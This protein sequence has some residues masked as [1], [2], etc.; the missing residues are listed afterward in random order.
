[1]MADRIDDG[2]PAYPTLWNSAHASDWLTENGMTLRDRFAI[3][4][5]CGMAASVGFQGGPWNKL[6]T[7]AYE[8]ADAMLVARSTKSSVEHA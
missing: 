8:A 3:A 6:S 1:M 4:A 5:L 7:D 2:G